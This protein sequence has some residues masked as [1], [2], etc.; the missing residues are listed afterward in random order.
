MWQLLTVESIFNARKE[1][2]RVQEGSR[3]HVTYDPLYIQISTS[4]TTLPHQSLSP[5]LSIT[6][7]LGRL[8]GDV[9]NLWNR[10]VIHSTWRSA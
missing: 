8:N 5:T 10:R 1:T 2:R 4:L 6:G 9:Y 3:V 7:P